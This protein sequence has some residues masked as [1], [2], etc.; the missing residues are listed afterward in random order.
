LTDPS[1]SPLLLSNGIT[2]NITG[3]LHDIS[4]DMIIKTATENSISVNRGIH[5]YWLESAL[6][7]S[8]QGHSSDIKHLI[9]EANNGGK[10]DFL[11]STNTI[12]GKAMCLYMFH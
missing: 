11:R 12:Y 5:P 7:A 4:N 10:W 6:N 8:E 1:D 2:T 3:D 9:D